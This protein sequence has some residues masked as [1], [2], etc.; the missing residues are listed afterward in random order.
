MILRGP[1]ILALGAAALPAVAASISVGNISPLSVATQQAMIGKAWN[2]GCP[3]PLSDLASVAVK[4]VGFDGVTRDGVIVIHKRFANDVAAIFVEL[5]AIRFPIKNISTYEHYDVGKSA[6]SDA[7]VGFYCRRAQDA[8]TEW[9]GHAYGA[10]IDINPI[11]N[12][13]ADPKDGWWPGGSAA[14]APRDN[15]QGKASPSTEAF[16]IFARHGWAWG[17]YYPGE[18]DFMHFY[19]LTVGTGN[20]LER[21]YVVNSMEFRPDAAP[22]AP[23]A[24]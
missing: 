16:R 17:G 22:S 18:P 9:S 15:G 10:A 23:S 11:E 19:K 20:P 13:F 8:P 5:Y 21:H 6:N 1:L 4:Y 3:V 12:P 14:N 24:R 2:S 7:T